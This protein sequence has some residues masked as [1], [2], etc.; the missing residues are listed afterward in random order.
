MI[1]NR[2][3]NSLD[4]YIHLLPSPKIGTKSETDLADDGSTK[5]DDTQR[6]FIVMRR[7]H[8]IIYYQV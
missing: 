5:C 6:C 8:S 7:N 3:E 1:S 2:N 4:T